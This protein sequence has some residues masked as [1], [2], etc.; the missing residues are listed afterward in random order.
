MIRT[1]CLLTL[2][3]VFLLPVAALAESQSYGDGVTL[4]EVTKVSNSFADPQA[5]LGK[6]VVVEG[7]VVK[8]CKKRGC[9]MDIAGDKEFEK[10]QVK[11]RDGVMVFPLSAMGKTARVQGTVEALEL[12]K[13]QAIARARHKADEQG[14]SCDLSAITGPQTVYRIRGTGAVIR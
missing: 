4:D 8:V 12:S 9:W 3:A 14:T 6:T 1:I 7:T 5:Y 11:V 13:E 10:I 2:L